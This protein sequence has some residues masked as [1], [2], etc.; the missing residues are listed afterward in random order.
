[1]KPQGYLVLLGVT[2]LAAS[3]V[4]TSGSFCT[5]ASPGYLASDDVA[6]YLHENDPRHEA[7]LIGINRF[8]ED[9]CG[10]EF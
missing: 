1:M 3:C 8:G 2:L 4:Q 9:H 5:V 10:W 6:D 7:W